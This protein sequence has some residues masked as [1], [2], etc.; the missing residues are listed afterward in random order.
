MAD[1]PENLRPQLQVLNTLSP[2][3]RSLAD[4]VRAIKGADF[5]ICD[6]TAPVRGV[7]GAPAPDP[8]APKRRRHRQK[9]AAPPAPTAG[10]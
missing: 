1:L 2:E 9:R 3:F 6:V 4:Q 5:S 8:P 7:A 10:V